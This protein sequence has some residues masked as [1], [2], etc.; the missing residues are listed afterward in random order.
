M[1]ANRDD[2]LLQR[3]QRT[4][5]T[6]NSEVTTAHEGLARQIG[7]ARS[8]LNA[9][10]ETLNRRGG[11]SSANGA[12]PLRSQAL[13]ERDNALRE[14]M[15]RNRV[16]EDSI[17]KL[18]DQSRALHRQLDLAVA[19]AED[20]RGQVAAYQEQE[21]AS[22]QLIERTEKELS[23]L[24]QSVETT[25]SARHAAR[26]ELDELKRSIETANRERASIE[27]Q[28][29]ALQDELESRSQ[30]ARQTELELKS[31]TEA[32][33]QLESRLAAE[34]QG[35]Q[36]RI[37]DLSSGL[38]STNRALQEQQD[39]I[40]SLTDERARLAEQLAL[41]QT[42]IEAAT[43][44][45]ERYEA[46]ARQAQR[47]LDNIQIL[48]EEHKQAEAA[49]RDELASERS[50]AEALR[51]SERSVR[52]ELSSLNHRYESQAERL[53]ETVR[54][55]EA[56]WELARKANHREEALVREMAELRETKESERSQDR[57]GTWQ[58]ESRLT[59]LTRE[60]DQLRRLLAESEAK[61]PAA[62]VSASSERD[63]ELDSVRQEL[64]AFEQLLIEREEAVEAAAERMHR[65]EA[66][67]LRVQAEVAALRS[68]QGAPAT[69]ATDNEEAQ[70]LHARIEELANRNAEQAARIIEQDI[71]LS[72]RQD[73]LASLREQIG[74]LDEGRIA[75]PERTP[76]DSFAFAA[77]DSNGHKKS[78]GEILVEAGIITDKQL[79]SALD[80]Q[81]SA[82]KRR[83]GSIL[84]EKGLIREEIVAQVVASQLQL[85]FV[86][87]SET[88][89]QRGAMALLDG[90]LATHHMCFPIS[91]TTE[92]VVVAMANPLDLIAIED[93]EFATHLKIR[94]VVATLSDITSAIVEYYGVSIVNAIA[95]DNFEVQTPAR[96]PAA[97][98]QP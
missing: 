88:K 74:A 77:H 64:L 87:L 2:I 18:E 27:A 4:I 65:L 94:P 19:E 76:E 80:E 26:E 81:R 36:E 5:D 55:L 89:I 53:A 71:E 54:E 22:A 8:Q 30:S 51:R 12:A 83:L 61:A 67:A 37:A 59:E 11:S 44:R 1:S 14:V 43:T 23:S 82:K 29:N 35:D 33:D 21:A 58:L 24:R 17:H 39:R 63:E 91:A 38:Q 79:D 78:M 96:A 20:L 3:L 70:A 62:P 46:A 41:A 28:R 52:E 47:E 34:R 90:R 69:N 49:I 73:E 48:L 95:E 72:Q 57:T 86:R 60:N 56:H 25:S 42:D 16:L 68:E 45:A 85:P 97:R 13:Q 40:A 66:T 75:A 84:V 31:L 50:E 32:L 6:W 15:Q 93:L 92:E 7:D 10:I 98:P 9:L